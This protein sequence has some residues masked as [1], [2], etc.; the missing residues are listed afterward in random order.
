MTTLKELSIALGLL[1]SDHSPTELVD[2]W[3]NYVWRVKQ[4]EH[5]LAQQEF[6]RIVSDRWDWKRPQ[7]YDAEFKADL[8]SNTITTR[9]SLRN[10]DADDGDQVCIVVSYLDATDELVAIFFA[11]W[12]SLPTR[13]YTREVPIRPSKPIKDITSVMVGSKQCDVRAIED[14]RNFQR[15]RHI[16]RQR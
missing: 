14:T 8:S 13:S 5:C 6:C 10:E 9:I 11:N 7:F 12:R 4:L 3:V 16:L 2:G 1:T 15:I